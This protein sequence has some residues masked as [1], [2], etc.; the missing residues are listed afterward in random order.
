MSAATSGIFLNSPIR[1][2]HSRRRAV[3]HHRTPVPPHR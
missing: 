2:A 3:S 1:F